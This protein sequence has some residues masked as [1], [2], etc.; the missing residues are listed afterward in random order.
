MTTT[1]WDMVNELYRRSNRSLHEDLEYYM[2]HGYIFSGPD[3]CLIGCR[4]G[5]GWYIQCAAGVGAMEHFC[6]FMPYYLP[7]IGWRREK[8]N[9]EIA[10]YPTEL[11][12]RKVNYARRITK[13]AETTS[14]TNKG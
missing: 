13:F 7:Y 4:I 8:R 3:Y 5:D 6:K 14:S 12:L 2:Q 1:I 9:N 11:I 10:W